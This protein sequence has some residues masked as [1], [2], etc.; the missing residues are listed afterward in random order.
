MPLSRP[1]P[2]RATDPAA[3]A[4]PIATPPSMPIQARAGVDLE[5]GAARRGRDVGQPH[6]DAADIQAD[7]GRGA[8]AQVGDVLVHLVGDVAAG[9]PACGT[10][11]RSRRA[12]GRALRWRS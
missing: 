11:A 4:A 2:S 6:V 9:A 1:N 5:D 12:P 3:T 10:R 8:A 7:H